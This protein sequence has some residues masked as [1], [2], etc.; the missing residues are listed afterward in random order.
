[1]AFRMTPHR[2][3]AQALES[4]TAAP[5]TVKV[6]PPTELKPRPLTNMTAEMIRLR[7]LVRSTWFSTM[8]RTPTAEIIP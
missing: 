5:P 8:L 6:M 3:D 7:D 4:V 1:M 2:A